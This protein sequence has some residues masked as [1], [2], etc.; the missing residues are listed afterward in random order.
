VGN[1]SA[2]DGVRAGVVDILASDYYPAAM[3]QA[4]FRAFREGAL[5]LAEA[6]ALVTA[7]PAKAA[8]LHDRGRIEAGLRADLV[9]VDDA[10]Y[11]R[12]RATLRAG[13]PVYRDASCPDI[14]VLARKQPPQM[15][16]L[17]ES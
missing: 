1:L 3:L 9:L 13:R 4:P 17:T 5:D 14:E 16:E 12:V 10:A 15:A 6:A 2:L 11:P 7:N 8:G